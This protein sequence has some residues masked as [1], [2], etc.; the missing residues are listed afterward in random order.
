[1]RQVGQILGD[2][3]RASE[4]ERREWISEAKRKKAKYLLV[5]CDTFSLEQYPVSC[6]DDE[7]KQRNLPNTMVRTCK[8]SRT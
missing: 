1:M 4:E 6:K 8:G 5:V 2:Q 3:M 7:D